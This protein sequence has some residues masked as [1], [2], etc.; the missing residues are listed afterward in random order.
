MKNYKGITLIALIITII[1]M[2]ILVSVTITIAINGGLFDYAKKAAK[3]TNMS[4]EDEQS[5][6]KGKVSVTGTEWSTTSTELQSVVDHYTK[7]SSNDAQELALTL[8]KTSLTYSDFTA[9]GSGTPYRYGSSTGQSEFSGYCCEINASASGGNKNYTY[10]YELSPNDQHAVLIDSAGFTLCRLE[11][12]T[13][14]SN[15]PVN[16]IVT[17]TATV[18]DGTGAAKSATCTIDLNG[19]H[20]PEEPI[21]FV[22]GTK[23][24]TENGLKNI[25]ELKAGEKVYSYNET[26][27]LVE[28]KEIK[29]VSKRKY[30]GTLSDVLINGEIIESTEKH[31]YYVIG[32]GYVAAN[33][34]EK[35]DLLLT[36]N[37][38]KLKVNDIKFKNNV[39][40]YVYNL[41]VEDNHNYFVGTQSVLVHNANDPRD[42]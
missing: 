9:I 7:T 25:E 31:K 27:N 37:G 1:V 22:S 2:L 21:C 10:T 8:N 26:M 41:H 4:I 19:L 16:G 5:L 12:Y 35:D 32:K 6:G 15:I 11:M 14:P 17:L 34:L 30:N 28:L 29:A 42:C 24:L 23:V 33:S 39:S 38:E 36:N 3:D 18:T 13:R 40:V 20:V